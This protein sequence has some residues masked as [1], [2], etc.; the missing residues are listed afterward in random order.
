[1]K[2]RFSDGASNGFTLVEVMVALFV[3]A[4]GLSS[5]AALL[6][7]SIS[8]TSTTEYMTQ[9]ATLTSEK[10]E[11]LNRYPAGDPNVAVTSGSTAGS[12][13]ADTSATVTSNS[14]TELVDYY[15]E[16]YLSPTAG[17]IS[18]SVSGLNSSGT[19]QY[20]T[21]T[22]QPN[23]DVNVT[24]TASNTSMINGNLQFERRWVIELN[25]TINGTQVNRLRRITVYVYLVNQSV[26][27]GVSF[28]MSLVR[29]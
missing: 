24:Q 12:I 20:T 13:T 2:S 25:P 22:Q 8:S 14:V 28:Q 29:P 15:D 23:G 16:I 7:S 4:I 1:M 19:V 9:A 10:L 17:S 21:T 6:A 11:D 18:E 5:V 3:L 26:M 27:P